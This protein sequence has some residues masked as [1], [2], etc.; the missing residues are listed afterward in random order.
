VQRDGAN[1]GPPLWGEEVPVDPGPHKI[2]ANAPHK[3]PWEG[4]VNVYVGGK[5][6][7]ASVPV[8]EDLP[9]PPP[10]QN[11]GDGPLPPSPSESDSSPSGGA[12]A[13]QKAIGGVVIGLGVVG[14]GLGAYF[15]IQALTKNNDSNQSGGGCDFGGVPDMCNANGTALRN[16]ALSAAK[17]STIAFVAGGVLAA[18]GIVVVLTAPRSH[19]R[20][21]VSFAP[22][23]HRDGAGVGLS[24]AW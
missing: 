16:D 24:G 7:D 6:V 2:T 1:V 22:L 9:E 17:G 19:H 8:L 20:E 5:N 15:G 12:G 10:T 18:A 13:A 3:K 14:L 11:V 21:N 23:L 4:T